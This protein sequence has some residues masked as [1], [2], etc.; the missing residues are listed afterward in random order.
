MTLPPLRD[1][2]RPALR[3]APGPAID[4]GSDRTRVWL[5]GRG[6]VAEVPTVTSPGPHGTRPVR[7]G[8]VVDPEGAAR[9]LGRLLAGLPRRSGRPPVAVLTTPV[10]CDAGHRA[11]LAAAL[12]AVPPALRPRTVLAVDSVR[13]VALGTGAAPDEPLLVV[14]LGAQLTEIALLADGAVTGAHRLPLGTADLGTNTTAA[15][16]AGAVVETV[17][18]MLRA[19][20]TPRTLDALEHGLLLSGGGARRPEVVHR[21]ARLLRTPV[22]PAPAPHAAAVRGAA[23]ALFPAYPAYP[24]SPASPGRHPALTTVLDGG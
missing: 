15:G 11:A 24:A 23:A 22:R 9:L 19:D 10:L 14:D 8:R 21:L 6:L 3:T 18:A 5:P 12:A 4:L 7:R 17:T 16:L 20:D 2:A 1:R 13:A